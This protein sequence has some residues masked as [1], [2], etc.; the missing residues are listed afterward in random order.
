MIAKQHTAACRV[1]HRHAAEPAALTQD[2][3]VTVVVDHHAGTGHPR[4]RRSDRRCRPRRPAQHVTPWY[5]TSPA[6]GS[7]AR[8]TDHGVS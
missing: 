7:P 5:T 4:R 6:S 2:A 3:T 8:P 1:H